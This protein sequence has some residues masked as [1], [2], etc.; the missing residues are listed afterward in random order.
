MMRISIWVV[1]VAFVL[2]WSG[3]VYAEDQEYIG[4]S[5]CKMC[6]N[7]KPE[8]AQWDV[9]KASKHAK[10]FEALSTDKAKEVAT[11]AG[12]K[13]PPAESPE[14]LRCHVTGYDAKAKAFNANAKLKKEEGVQCE[15]CHGP[16]SLHQKDGAAKMQ[17]KEV[18][19]KAH[20]TPVTEAICVTCHNKE[21]PTDDGKP[22]DFKAMSEKI[23]HKNPLK[24]AAAK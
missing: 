2:A 10:A 13:T 20:R 16:S 15:S 9:W 12:L 22:F 4:N 18:D 19:M 11:K 24:A 3:A 23:A 7:K 17:K 5:A 1:L 8:G 14:C 21:N 6:H